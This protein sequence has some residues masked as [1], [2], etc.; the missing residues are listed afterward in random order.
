MSSNHRFGKPRP[1][2]NNRA[3]M[4]SRLK[5]LGVLCATAI[6]LAACGS[7]PAPLSAPAV[8][9]ADQAESAAAAP[10]TA[11]ATAAP[12]AV[13]S[14][15]SP[16]GDILVGSNGLAVYGFTN[17]VDATSACYGTCAEAWPPVIVGPDWNVAPGLDSG[18]FNAFAR[19]DGQ[20]Q[21]VAGKWP[22]YY[23]AGDAIP[24]DLNG[25]GSGDVWFVVGTDGKLITDP[26]DG[27]AD[28]AANENS[29][30]ETP[31]GETAASETPVAVG[32]TDLGDVLVDQAGLSL[33]GFLDDAD[34]QPTCE[35]ACADAWPPLLVDS[36]DLPAGLDSAVF[37]VVERPD[38]NFQLKAGK[39]PLY[40]FAGDAAPGDTNGQGSGEVWFLATPDGGLI[41]DVEQTAGTQTG[42]DG[43]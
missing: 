30:D 10:D 35:G 19:E 39:W 1:E 11:P 42:G 2:R 8:D 7:D 26:V 13:T 38:G 37:S 22:L 32:A 34:G 31:A 4:P 21:L 29:A 15:S 9:A 33:Y 14:S 27:S 40:L 36:A 18:I 17:D 12:A 24:T 43:Y 16:L 23:F 25:Q 5:L 6:G 41:K 28:E 20:L 3:S